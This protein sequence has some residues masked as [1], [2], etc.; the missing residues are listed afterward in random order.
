MSKNIKMTNLENENNLVFMCY[1]IA[2]LV[3]NK[4][5]GSLFLC[6]FYVFCFFCVCFHRGYVSGG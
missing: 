6:M 3:N 5:S 1:M 2:A 4:S